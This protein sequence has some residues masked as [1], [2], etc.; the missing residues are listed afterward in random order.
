MTEEEKTIPILFYGWVV[1]GTRRADML[2]ELQATHGIAIT[3]SNM[4]AYK[5]AP[6]QAACQSVFRFPC[7]ECVQ[8]LQRSFDSKAFLYTCACNLA[9]PELRKC[10]C[11]ACQ[12]SW[13]GR[14][15]RGNP[16][17]AF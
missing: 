4:Q 7:K 13:R 2:H 11:W 9:V 17:V 8:G 15:E 14:V 16:A 1:P 3:L 12:P 10:K 6:A 5:C